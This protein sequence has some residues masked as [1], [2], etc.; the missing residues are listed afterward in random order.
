MKDL[1]VYGTPTLFG[2]LIQSYYFSHV[3]NYILF[4][5]YERNTNMAERELVT[6][7]NQYSNVAQDGEATQSDTWQ[8]DPNRGADKAIDGNING[9]WSG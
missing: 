5:R 9:A 2:S 1:T 8:D 7:T 3:Y 4:W 6:S